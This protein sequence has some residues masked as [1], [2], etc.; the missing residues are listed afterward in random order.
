MHFKQ[1][2]LL[3]LNIT[4]GETA[5]YSGTSNKGHY[6]NNLR[7]KDKSSTTKYDWRG[8]FRYVFKSCYEIASTII[9]IQDAKKTKFTTEWDMVLKDLHDNFTPCCTCAEV[10]TMIHD[11]WCYNVWAT[12]LANWTHSSG[13]MYSLFRIALLTAMVWGMV[14]EWTQTRPFSPTVVSNLKCS[15]S[16]CSI[17]QEG[18]SNLAMVNSV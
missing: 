17:G 2:I 6:R 4:A 12:L 1:W 13:D 3:T 11:R 10:V 14:L 18:D 15:P 5:S 16:A 7:I 9:I 8:P